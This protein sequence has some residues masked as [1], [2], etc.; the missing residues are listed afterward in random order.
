RW[1]FDKSDGN[2]DSIATGQWFTVVNGDT[3]SNGHVWALDLGR[4]TA[5]IHLGLRQLV[6]D[7]L[8]HGIYYFRY[9]GI[10]GSALTRASVQKD[11]SV[12][13]MFYGIRA[14]GLVLPLEPV[15]TEYDLLFTQY[16]TLLFTNAGA[17]YPYLVTGVLSN[18]DGVR[19]AVDSVHSFSSIDLTLARTM[20]YTS[21]L[22][23]IGYDWKVY[24]FT[25]DSYTVKT[26]LAYIITNSRGYFYKLR[27]TGFYKSG[28]KG[29]PIIETQ[30]L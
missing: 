5:G 28:I 26:N 14:G 19:V 7:S 30:R 17:A 8:K 16:T 2:P 12:N 9:A 24:S 1:K 18:S 13:Y 4:D 11:P 25:A 23:A 21:A 10:N 6:F 20:N 22:D 3:L 27:F 15:K 29:Y